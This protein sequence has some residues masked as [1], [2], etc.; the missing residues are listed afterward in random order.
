VILDSVFINGEK[1]VTDKEYS[2]A[3][4]EFLYGGSDGYSELT[5][6]VMIDENRDITNL[7]DICL[8]YFEI[9]KG[10]K[11]DFNCLTDSDYLEPGIFG[12]DSSNKTLISYIRET[13]IFDNEIPQILISSSA[14]IQISE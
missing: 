10:L 1:L 4:R 8:K 3:T 14:R 5:K 9:V 13:V 11:D 2:L 7:F 12:F 6:C